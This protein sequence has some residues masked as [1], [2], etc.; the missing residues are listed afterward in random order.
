LTEDFRV[1]ENVIFGDMNS[2][3]NLQSEFGS[4]K[5]LGFSK[6]RNDQASFQSL[7]NR[8]RQFIKKLKESPSRCSVFS[9]LNS[10]SPLNQSSVEKL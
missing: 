9:P 3:V 4:R 6:V 5:N 8:N 10:K 7:L 2:S 1:D